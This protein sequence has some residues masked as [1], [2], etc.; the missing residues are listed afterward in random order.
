MFRPAA[1]LRPTMFSP[2]SRTI[3]IV[4]PTMSHGF[5]LS[6]SQKTER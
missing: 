1:S 4:P 5:S 3:T 6:G 2:T